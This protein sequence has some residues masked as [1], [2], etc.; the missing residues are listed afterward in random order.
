M[1]A[2]LLWA[3]AAALLMGVRPAFSKEIRDL[4]F[5]VSSDK[6]KDVVEKKGAL[7]KLDELYC[8]VF[9][10][11]D[12]FAVEVVGRVDKEVKQ[13]V[14][15]NCQRMGRLVVP[16]D[17]KN[18]LASFK[19]METSGGWDVYRDDT[20]VSP[21]NEILIKKTKNQMRLIEKR[22]TGTTKLKYI[23]KRVGGAKVLKKVEMSSYEGIQN[24]QTTSTL[25]YKKIS[26][27]LLPVK[28]VIDTTQ[29]LVRKEVGDF[30]RKLIETVEFKNYS[31]NDSKALMYF[32]KN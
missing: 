4:A 18:Y 32:N 22:P 12:R 6:I 29:N 28:A 20:G 23:Y 16:V 21:I 2:Q 9:W 27:H 11:K 14:A 13:I 8:K 24:V 26:G 31:V 10:I 5:H 30:T 1:K 15:E 19:K 7:K 17:I 25:R 3:M